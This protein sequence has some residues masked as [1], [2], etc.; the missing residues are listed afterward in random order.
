MSGTHDVPEYHDGSG[1]Y[2]IRL[3]GHLDSRWSDRFEG[4][5]LT[6]EEEGDTLLSGPVADQPALHGLLKRIRDLGIPL[7]SVNRVQ[8][9]ETHPYHSKKEK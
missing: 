1:F 6:L 8:F 2:E 4:L 3:Q 5:T 7:V 9:N